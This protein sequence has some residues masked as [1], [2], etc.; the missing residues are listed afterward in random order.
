[1][2]CSKV[3]CGVHLFN[4]FRR[5]SRLAS[6][7]VLSVSSHRSSRG[8]VRCRAWHELV[9]G[10]SPGDT[11]HSLGNLASEIGTS[12]AFLQGP[13]QRPLSRGAANTP[14]KMHVRSAGPPRTRRRCAVTDARPTQLL[15]PPGSAALGSPSAPSSRRS[16]SFF[17]SPRPKREPRSPG[18]GP[19]CFLRLRRTL[20]FGC[21]GEGAEARLRLFLLA[22]A[23]RALVAFP[24]PLLHPNAGAAL[25][26]RRPDTCPAL[27]PAC[28]P[29]SRP[30][31]NHAC[32]APTQFPRTRRDVYPLTR[33]PVLPSL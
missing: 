13:P 7:C 25:A 33:A 22:P 8:A 2:P 32:P 9:L 11:A 18:L 3:R 30:S 24:G 15:P 27:P 29:P 19:S 16:S 1:M 28:S 31:L 6:G 17:L 26:A 21:R 4:D 10:S 14:R 12:P 5:P 20:V 23:L